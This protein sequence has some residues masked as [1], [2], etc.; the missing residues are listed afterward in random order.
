M[1]CGPLVA[2]IASIRSPARQFLGQRF[3]SGLRD[4]QR[5]CCEAA[6]PLAVPGVARADADPATVGTAADWLLRFLARPKPDMHLAVLGVMQYAKSRAISLLTA[7]AEI[8]ES[9]G[10]PR[11]R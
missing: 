11:S 2:E 9:L 5:R 7:F 10:P 6:P 1:I 3:T 4:L 8:A